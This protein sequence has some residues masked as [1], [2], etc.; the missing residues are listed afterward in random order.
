MSKTIRIASRKSELALT[1][2]KEVADYIRKHTDFEVEIIPMSTKGDQV[3]EKS[4]SQIGGKGLF[5]QELES[6]LKTGAVDLCVHSLKDMPMDVDEA[7]PIIGY[8]KR[9]D[10]RDVLVLPEGIREWDRTKPIGTSSPRRRQQLLQQHPSLTIASVRGNIATRLRKLDEGQF[11][12][13][14]LAAAGL[15]R[16]GLQDRINKY[17]SIQEM[18][19]AAGQG[20]LAIQGRLGEDYRYLEGFFCEESRLAAIAERAFVRELGGGCSAPVAAHAVVEEDRMKLYGFCDSYDGSFQMECASGPSEKAEQTGI[21]L[22]RY[23]RDGM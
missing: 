10:A 8:S 9:E 21:G 22:A 14:I 18:L 19:P 12:A 13:L 7:V 23:M 2:T 11:G 6:A 16:L 4:L 17:F 3:L 1:Q 20:I 15:H 5:V